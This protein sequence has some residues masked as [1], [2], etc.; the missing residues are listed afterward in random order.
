M[1]LHQLPCVPDPEAMH[2]M[3]DTLF[4]HSVHGLIELAW[5]TPAPGTRERVKLENAQLFPLD[6]DNRDALVQFAC[7]LNA[8]PN[9]N[10]YISAGLRREDV[11]RRHRHGND[12]VLSVAAVKADC[13]KPGCLERSLR[14]C[15][16]QRMQPTMVVFTGYEPHLRGSLWWVLDQPAP[17]EELARVET[18]ER[19]LVKL[20]GSDPAVVDPSR[21]MRLAGGV[22]WP[23]KAGRVLEMTGILR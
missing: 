12:A 10:V 5:T 14:I 16:E 3:I 21:V 22:A 20:F 2:T 13:D 4:A 23:I 17:R 6:D 7:E 9:T 11:D 19:S 1:T 15:Q 8:R 18:M